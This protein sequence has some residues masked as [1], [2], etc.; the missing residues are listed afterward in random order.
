VT[1]ESM[2]EI[3]KYTRGFSCGIIVAWM[4]CVASVR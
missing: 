3:E 4:L 2:K 1:K